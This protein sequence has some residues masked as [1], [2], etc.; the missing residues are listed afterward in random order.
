ME[1]FITWVLYMGAAVFVGLFIL[2]LIL[3]LTVRNV[4]DGLGRYALGE[5]DEHGE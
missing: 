1:N 4:L 5:E 2:V 3:S